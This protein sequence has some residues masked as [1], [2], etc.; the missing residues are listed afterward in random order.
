MTT[1]SRLFDEL[2]ER[3][4]R[5]PGRT[6]NLP[7]LH[8]REAAVLVPMFE[9]DGVPHILFTKR[10]TTLRSH[11]GQFSFPGGAR[12]PSDQ[13]PLHAALRETE[14]EVGIPPD[15]VK[16][17]GMLDESP[18][19]TQYRIQPFVGVIPADLQ[20]RPNPDE[21]ELIL[22]VPLPA[23]LS[24]HA[25]R[26]ELWRRGSEEHVVYFFEYESHVIWGATARILVNLFERARGAPQFEA[27]RQD[28]EERTR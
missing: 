11:A 17:L 18:T 20:Y 28:A 24:P 4:H 13:T 2:K 7:G 15:A 6:L 14:E 3:L 8:L 25:S 9:R 21:I 23:L 5:E 26:T 1:V 10:P 16:V 27:L 12:D 19:I 22:E